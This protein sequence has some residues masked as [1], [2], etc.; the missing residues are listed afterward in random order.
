MPKGSG[1]KPASPR[2]GRKAR[3][4]VYQEVTD[5]IVGLLE[6]GVAPWKQPLRAG[7]I[8]DGLPKNLTSGKPYRGVNVFLLAMTAWAGGY[9]SP[10]WTTFKQAK[11]RGGSVKKGEK[12]TQVIFWK[13]FEKE[14]RQTGEIDK[15]PVLR[16]Y[17]VFNAAAQ[18]EGL[19]VPGAAGIEELPPFEPIAECE[20]IV[21]GF[22]DGPAVQTAP[23]T[24][25][26]RPGADTVR[27]PEAAAFETPE[28][29]YATIYHEF[30]HATGH[31][32]R[33]NRGL[34]A[35]LAPFGSADYSKEELVAEMASAFLCAAS[36]IGPAT[37]ENSAAYVE[38]WAKKLRGDKRL[39][40]TAAAAGQKA[41]DWIRDD[42]P[43]PRS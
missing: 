13:L 18:C 6:S 4:D 20:A 16:H 2:G 28:S 24:P 43:E 21:R 1:R 34:D 37:V 23:G 15:L 38:G 29:Y 32:S 17:T 26:Y 11:E 36:G 10:H 9:D 33:L 30:A 35:A 14:D 3:R 39:V 42:R 7:F 5:R 22:A 31:S 40:V 41:A 27:M 19:E 25:C 12:G 8:G